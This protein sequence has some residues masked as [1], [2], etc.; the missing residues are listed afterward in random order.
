MSGGFG[1][2]FF[3][4][5]LFSLIG[6]S[7]LSLAM[8]LT[9]VDPGKASQVDLTTPT[10]S[11]FN[12]ERKDIN[13]VLP[14]TDQSV[15]KEG[16]SKPVSE[17]TPENPATDTTTAK[18]PQSQSG[19]ELGSVEAGD[20]G[21]DVTTPKGDAP[22]VNTPPV[23]GL[24]MPEIDA[25]VREI[26]VNRLPV[27]DPPATEVDAPPAIDGAE[28][29]AADALDASTVAANTAAKGALLRNKTVFQNP[30]GKPLMSIILLDAGAEGLKKED[31]LTFSFPVTFALDPNAA[32]VTADAK[33][34]AR[35][36]FEVLAMAPTGTQALEAAENDADIAAALSG[37]FARIPQ[38]VGLVDQPEAT[39]QQSPKLAA[40][41]IASFEE[42]GHGLLTYDIGLNSTD[43]KARSAGIYADT[44]FR[45]LDSEG[46]NATKI[47]RYLNRAVLEAGK[48][49]SVIVI[50]RTYPETVTALF[51]WALSAKSATISL[52]PVSA[53]LLG[54]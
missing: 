12:A 28:S 19:V 1:I 36:G 45:V 49:G 53:V 14:D 30:S 48:N 54:E 11:G 51:S 20:A 27:V 24:P 35:K 42:T 29:S 3:K 46:E 21:A 15:V 38:A 9:P 10:G 22:L 23:L 31:L 6:L 52:A 17:A 44:V 33:V 41:V 43:Q 2:G 37:I 47:K 40:Q 32:G 26:P 5:T 18:Q 4:G 34:Y 50:G 39:L 7:A 16:V 13:P 8:P 25:P